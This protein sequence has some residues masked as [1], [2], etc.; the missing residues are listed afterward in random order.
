MAARDV[1]NAGYTRA[2]QQLIA[3]QRDLLSAQRAL[4]DNN[5][6]LQVRCKHLDMRS[7]I[8]ADSVLTP[9]AP[10]LLRQPPCPTPLCQL[11]GAGGPDLAAGTAISNPRAA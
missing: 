7:A 8:N 9:C 5:G 10:A 3:T 6:L 4:E 11:P 2:Q 1:S